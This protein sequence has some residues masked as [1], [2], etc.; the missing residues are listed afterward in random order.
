MRPPKSPPAPELRDEFPIKVF[1]SKGNIMSLLSRFIPERIDTAA[2]LHDAVE[3]R[4][5]YG[6]EAELWCEAG[7]LSSTSR[8]TRRLLG[9][10]HKALEQVPVR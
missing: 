1:V 9:Q 6:C 3:L 5:R 4:R 7:M 2:V 8:P 10:I